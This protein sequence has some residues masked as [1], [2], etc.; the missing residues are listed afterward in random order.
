MDQQRSKLLLDHVNQARRAM[1]NQL[2]AQ[3]SNGFS[4]GD[5]DDQFIARALDSAHKNFEGLLTQLEVL[6]RARMEEGGS[7]ATSA[8]STTGQFIS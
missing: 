6:L 4:A 8:C 7:N 1:P 2:L 5:Y 3:I